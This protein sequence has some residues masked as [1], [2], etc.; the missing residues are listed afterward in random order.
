MWLQLEMQL[1]GRPEGRIDHVL[2]CDGIVRLKAMLGA[3][4][5]GLIV[6]GADD[7]SRRAIVRIGAPW[8]QE[9]PHSDLMSLNKVMDRVLAIDNHRA[10]DEAFGLSSREQNSFNC[11][12]RGLIFSDIFARDFE[13]SVVRAFDASLVVIVLA[14]SADDLPAKLRRAG[15]LANSLCLMAPSMDR[16]E[17]AWTAVL[18]A[19]SDEPAALPVSRRL[20]A[21]SPGYNLGDFRRAMYEAGGLSRSPAEI[22]DQLLRT[23]ERLMPRS[24]ALL[25]FVQYGAGE[26]S[27][28]PSPDA[29]ADI[30]GYDGIKQAMQK[31]AEWPVTKRDSLQ[32]L[33]VKPPCGLLLHGPSGCGKTLLASAL[34]KSNPFANWMNVD[35]PSLFSKYLG[36]TEA[37]LRAVF[38]Q[39]RALEPCI[40]FLDELD[41]LGGRQDAEDNSV[42][43]R[44]LGTLLAELDGATSTNSVFILACTN[45][46]TAIDPALI[47]NGRIDQVFEVGLPSTQDRQSIFGVMTSQVPIVLPKDMSLDDCI[48]DWARRT[49]GYSGSDIASIF[50]SA[51]MATMRKS[52]Q[53]DAVSSSHI[54]EAI[55]AYV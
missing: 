19:L 46:L 15:R 36:D 7:L 47:R 35:V 25:D 20:A 55:S 49:E 53:P 34:L 40:V 54:D 48:S 24:A 21:V 28:R 37:R 14:P 27:P 42:E 26:A 23:A 10:N 4:V 30:G 33:G 16:R 29:W 8:A 1:T 13:R 45:R 41:A 3:G 31:A 50:R 22:G 44:L 2:L 6:C 11:G 51:A 5:S 52:R 38:A 18:N 43:R 9:V 12:R 32:K 39:A 17:A